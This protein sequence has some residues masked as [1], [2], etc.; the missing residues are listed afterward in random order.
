MDR[1]SD[2]NEEQLRDLEAT[3][4][5]LKRSID[6]SRELVDTARRQLEQLKAAIKH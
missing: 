2:N 1:V 6:R 5:D 4:Q 3:Q